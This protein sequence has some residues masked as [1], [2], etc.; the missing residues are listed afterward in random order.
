MGG[1]I[2]VIVGIAVI[3]SLP[4]SGIYLILAW[5]TW[6]AP[7]DGG[8]VIARIVA[9]LAALDLGCSALAG[10]RAWDGRGGLAPALI[11]LGLSALMIRM[12]A[13]LA[14]SGAEP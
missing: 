1:W 4:V 10:W 13:G 8:R 5:T 3:V 11:S 14:R 6:Q 7:A 2:A 12:A 9:L